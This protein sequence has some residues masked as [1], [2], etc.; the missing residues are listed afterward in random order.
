MLEQSD[1][2]IVA[3]FNCNELILLFA[4]RRFSDL[5][6]NM[7]ELKREYRERQMQLRF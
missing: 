5:P 1:A 2:F 3:T 4:I 6:Y 7:F